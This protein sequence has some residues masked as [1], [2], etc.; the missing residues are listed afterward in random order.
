MRQTKLPKPT[1]LEMLDLRDEL[2]KIQD[3]FVAAG[4]AGPGTLGFFDIL[5]GAC[6]LQAKEF[7]LQEVIDAERLRSR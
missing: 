3:K 6:E 2:L 7:A 1:A 4:I 5:V